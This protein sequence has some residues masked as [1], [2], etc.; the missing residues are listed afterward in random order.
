MRLVGIGWADD[1]TPPLLAFL[2]EN[3]TELP[4]GKLDLGQER[5][6]FRTGKVRNRTGR[7]AGRDRESCRSGQ[8]QLFH[9][10]H[11]GVLC[12]NALFSELTSNSRVSEFRFYHVRWAF[13]LYCIM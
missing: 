3:G 9:G 7:V 12:R 1:T 2:R 5:F 4:A 6:G 11:F 8:R 13:H 10:S